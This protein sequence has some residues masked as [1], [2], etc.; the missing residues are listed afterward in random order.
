MRHRLIGVNEKVLDA[1]MDADL[2]QTRRTVV[3]VL[4]QT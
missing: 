4:A 2:D 3:P 1:A